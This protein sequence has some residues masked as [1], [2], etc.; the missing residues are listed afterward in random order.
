RLY[1][2]VVTARSIQDSYV[3]S[4]AHGQLDRRPLLT[5]LTAAV[6]LAVVL[7][8]AAVTIFWPRPLKAPVI[9]SFTANMPDVLAGD[10]VTL[11]W[12]ISDLG[13]RS[14]IKPDN[15]PVN[16]QVG[17][18]VVK[19]DKTTNYELVARNGTHETIRTLTVT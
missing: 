8:G 11:Q 12:D 6:L 3:S 16:A 7:L 14:V 2:F 5:T 10:P 15:I 1:G 13:E 9:H 17:S 19:P 18:V 4:N